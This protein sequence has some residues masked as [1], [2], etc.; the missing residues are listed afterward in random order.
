MDNSYQQKVGTAARC[1]FCNRN[2][3]QVRK[4]IAGP[5]GVYICDNCVE[6]A[7]SIIFTDNL[8]NCKKETRFPIP[9]EIKKAL[10][11]Y[12]IRHATLEFECEECTENTRHGKAGH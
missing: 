6:V 3:S 10:E 7:H 9:S 8:E 11:K 2:Q 5:R 1:N 12:N 4:L